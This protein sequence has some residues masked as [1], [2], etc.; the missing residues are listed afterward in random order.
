[1]EKPMFRH[2]S[3]EPFLQEHGLKIGGQSDWWAPSPDC[4]LKDKAQAAT[5]NPGT[6]EV[7]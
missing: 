2:L 7:A 4:R 5:A 3:R 1:M 6:H